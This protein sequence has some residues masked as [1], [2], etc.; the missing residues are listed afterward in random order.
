LCVGCHP[1]AAFT[2]YRMPAEGWETVVQEMANRGM[3]GNE[4][5]RQAVVEYLAK[6]LGPAAGGAA[7]G[8]PTTNQR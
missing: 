5:E 7:N 6:N 8:S 1:P 2:K 4:Q 3:P